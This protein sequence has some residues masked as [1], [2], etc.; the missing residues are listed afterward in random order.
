M[1]RLDT[2]ATHQ[3]QNCLAFLPDIDFFYSASQDVIELLPEE[4]KAHMGSILLKIENFAGEET[5]LD[6]NITDRYDLLGLY[7]GVPI[8]SKQQSNNIPIPDIIFLYRA[9]LIRYAR[10]HNESIE[11]IIR[12]V[13]VHEMGHHFGFSSKEIDH[14]T[15]SQENKL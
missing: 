1:H 5:L 9:P 6:L 14:M 12:H 2:I 3:S 7:R 13:L 4:L 8:P 15:K 11:S 10:E